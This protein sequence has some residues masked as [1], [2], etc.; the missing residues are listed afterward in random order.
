[1]SPCCVYSY[2]WDPGRECPD[3]LID[4]CSRLRYAR[5]PRT[6]NVCEC[7][8]SLFFR[9]VADRSWDR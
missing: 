4:M 9:L 7:A 8:C 6:E 1:M 2:V 5:E 3:R